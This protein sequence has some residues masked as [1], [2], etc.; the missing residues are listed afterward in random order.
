MN[1]LNIGVIGL[2]Y[3]GKTHVYNCMRLETANLIA[4]AD[5]SKNAL[6]KAK[7]NGVPNIYT[8]Y[9]ELLKNPHIDAV[10]IALPT[11]LHAKCAISAAEAHKHIL[12]EK[13]I[14]R[15]SFEANE[16]LS[17][18]RSNNVKLMI[19]HPLRF[20][21]PFIALK[22][23][24]DTGEMGEIQAS[25]AFNINSGPFVHRAET[26]APM[27]VPDWWWNKDY[28]GGGALI[29]LGSHMINLARW[30]FGEVTDVK[31]YLGY[32][33][34]LDQEDHAICILKFKGG[35]VTIVNV[36]W[37]SGK[38][39]LQLDVHGTCGL[40]VAALKTASKIKTVTKMALR[41]TPPYYIP[42]LKEIEH[43]VESIR[44]DQQPEPSGED[45]L[46]D[47]DA[48]ELAYKN[49]INLH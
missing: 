40:G 46:K 49:Q 14:S 8:D 11:H 5:I 22:K 28:T 25:Y 20:S 41:K 4:V 34:N 2:G 30:Y 23:R 27:P 43:F 35:Q 37:Y 15:N 10:I 21:Q 33:F 26:G 19:G 7:R 12:L 31:S 48:I 38:T 13:P 44:K 45:G 39:Q 32:R 42:F 16:I 6:N 47:L 1:K 29:D 17:K 18:V 24:I 3:I 9:Q 36:G